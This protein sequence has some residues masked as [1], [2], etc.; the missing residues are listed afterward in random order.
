MYLVI[1]VLDPQNKN[2][3]YALRF[4]PAMTTNISIKTL[5]PQKIKSALNTTKGKNTNNNDNDIV[6]LI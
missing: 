1:L 3:L 5:N 6:Y 4:I 2:V